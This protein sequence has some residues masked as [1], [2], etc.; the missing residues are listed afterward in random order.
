MIIF[1]CFL[2]NAF[3]YVL[4]PEIANWDRV[5][6]VTWHQGVAVLA[7]ILSTKTGE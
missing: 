6:E 2:A 5:L 4:V 3:L 1:V 7:Y